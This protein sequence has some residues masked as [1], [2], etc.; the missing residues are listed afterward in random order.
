MKKID[1]WYQIPQWCFAILMPVSTTKLTK[2]SHCYSINQ[3]LETLASDIVFLWHRNRWQTLKIKRNIYF[4][5]YKVV[6]IVS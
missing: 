3:R 1:A 6:I 5:I 2:Y 4:I